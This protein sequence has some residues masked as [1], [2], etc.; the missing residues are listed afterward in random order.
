MSALTPLHHIAYS[1]A[2]LIDLVD[3]QGVESAE[4]E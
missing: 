3:A 4:S 1:S 2:R